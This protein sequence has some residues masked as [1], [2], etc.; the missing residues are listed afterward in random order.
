MFGHVRLVRG[1]INDTKIGQ[2]A[3]AAKQFQ[4]RFDKRPCTVVCAVIVVVV[5]LVFVVVVA[6][7]VLLAN[8]EIV[9]L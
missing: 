4:F 5:V 8:S 1:Q 3:I 7:V 6:V 2:N 9:Q